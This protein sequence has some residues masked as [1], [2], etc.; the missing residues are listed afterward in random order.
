MNINPISFGSEIIYLKDHLNKTKTPKAKSAPAT[1]DVFIKSKE[2]EQKRTLSDVNEDMKQI[3]KDLRG[4]KTTPENAADKFMA[5]LKDKRTME[6][7]QQETALLDTTPS[8]EIDTRKVENFYRLTYQIENKLEA[9][10]KNRNKSVLVFML[11]EPFDNAYQDYEERCSEIFDDLDEEEDDDETLSS[12]D[13]NTLV[14]IDDKDVPEEETREVLTNVT[15]GLK[16][17]F[18]ADPEP[19]FDISVRIDDE[20]DEK[21][22]IKACTN[23]FKLVTMTR[24]NAGKKLTDK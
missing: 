3:L 13:L 21:K 10:L 19:E 12:I 2:Q 20:Y 5:L 8:E 24:E 6:A 18:A 22:F 9:T 4:R 17:M 1:S 16:D 23:L 14:E 11:L 15:Q 7:F